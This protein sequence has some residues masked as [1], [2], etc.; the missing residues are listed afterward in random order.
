MGYASVAA[1][2]ALDTWCPSAPGGAGKQ[3]ANCNGTEVATNCPS[4]CCDVETWNNA[5]VLK[6]KGM[7]SLQFFNERRVRAAL[8][9]L[10][11]P[12]PGGDPYPAAQLAY[13]RGANLAPSLQAQL[14]QALVNF[15]TLFP[16]TRWTT[17]A[18]CVKTDCSTSGYYSCYLNKPTSATSAQLSL[19]KA[20]TGAT[21]TEAQWVGAQYGPHYEL[22]S[23]QAFQKGA[24]LAPTLVQP[25]PLPAAAQSWYQDVLRTI[26]AV[27]GG[28]GSSNHN[29]VVRPGAN[30]EP[31]LLVIRGGTVVNGQIK[32]GT[33][34]P[35]PWLAQLVKLLV[36]ALRISATAALTPGIAQAIRGGGGAT[37]SSSTAAQLST[38]ASILG[39]GNV[40]PTV[41]RTEQQG[42][43][44]RA[45]AGVS[46]WL[47]LGAVAVVGSGAYFFMRR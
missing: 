41:A 39:R 44:A 16:A 40:A 47:I 20:L 17:R 2:G 33:V 37:V 4:V 7:T 18:D 43:T 30:P 13:D 26:M 22:P 25:P 42:A 24:S 31:S 38:M 10:V 23:M 29:F 28:E 45:G 12:T 6:L 8:Q 3:L 11:S 21:V 5:T 27:P 46:P 32:G 35:S 9:L 34:S 36:P 15:D 1:L 19:L 14:Q